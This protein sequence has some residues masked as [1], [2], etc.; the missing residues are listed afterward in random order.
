MEIPISAITCPADTSL[1]GHSFRKEVE[2]PASG[3]S[4]RASTTAE[5]RLPA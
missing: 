1:S 2:F 5:I 4:L 3:P